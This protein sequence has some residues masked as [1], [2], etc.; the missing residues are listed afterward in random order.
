VHLQDSF[1]TA[2]ACPK[3]HGVFGAIVYGLQA[4]DEGG[5]DGLRPVVGPMPCHPR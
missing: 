2:A 4:F 1:G 3:E 5:L